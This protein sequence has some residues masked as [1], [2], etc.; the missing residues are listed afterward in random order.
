MKA[1]GDG[2]TG[3]VLSNGDKLDA[4]NKEKVEPMTGWRRS[5]NQEKK[6]GIAPV[7]LPATHSGSRAL[8]RGLDSIF[9]RAG[10][11]EPKDF[12]SPGIIKWAEHLS[13]FKNVSHLEWSQIIRLHAIGFEYGTQSSVVVEAVDDALDMNPYLLSPEGK[14]LVNLA[15][16]CV[17]RTDEAIAALGR[18]AGNLCQASGGDGKALVAGARERAKSEAYFEIDSVFRSWFA[19]LGPQS[20]PSEV[21]LEWCN[22]ARTVL[23]GIASKL[24]EEASPNAIVGTAIKDSKGKVFWVTAAKAEALFRKALYEALPD[25]KAKPNEKEG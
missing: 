11:T 7:Y 9:S 4:L 16:E 17:E 23:K 18:F 21:R 14:K 24:M 20:D 2:V 10:A 19:Q 1:S 22:L 3:L 5:P 15:C 6:L 25:N 12:L 13:Q 8:W